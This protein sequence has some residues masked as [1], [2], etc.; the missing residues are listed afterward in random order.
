MPGERVRAVSVQ[1]PVQRDDERAVRRIDNGRCVV[2]MAERGEDLA[3]AVEP[4]RPSVVRT[5]VEI[6]HPEVTAGRLRESEDDVRRHLDCGVR[7]LRQ[8]P[9]EHASALRQPQHVG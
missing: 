2:R 4:L 8:L 9:S 5:H 1:Q 7:R 6:R 3:G